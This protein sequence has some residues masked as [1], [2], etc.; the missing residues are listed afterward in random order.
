MEVLQASQWNQSLLRHHITSKSQ[1]AV[2]RRMSPISSPTPPSPPTEKLST[3]SRA[4]GLAMTTAELATQS[5]SAA[6]K[7]EESKAYY[8][9]PR[10]S[11]QRMGDS[12]AIDGSSMN[13]LFDLSARSHANLNSRSGPPN[14]AN[15]FGLMPEA[16]HA[17]ECISR[18]ASGADKWVAHPPFRFAVEFWDVA[19]LREK[20]RLHSHTIWYAGSLFNV[21]VQVVRKKGLQ[22]GVYLHRQS[23][24]DPTPS[25]STFAPTIRSSSSMQHV[26]GPSVPNTMSLPAPPP[27][28]S[29]SLRPT[30]SRVST[31]M[32]ISPA[33][34][35]V[36]ISSSPM[37]SNSAFYSSVTTTSSSLSSSSS[38]SSAMTIPA[39]TASPPP[40]QPYRDPRAAVTAYFSIACANATGSSLTRFTSAPDEFKVSQSWGWKSSSL[41]TEEYLDVGPDG[42]VLVVPRDAS[43]GRTKEISLRATVVIGVV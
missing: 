35:P 13:H 14:E 41:R 19:S 42:E 10:D 26:R 8:H 37:Q 3:E 6:H 33:T 11:S 9:V 39:A 22:L 16:Y 30:E 1:G 32:P 24:V 40:P 20:N 29:P 23:H 5:S 38:S 7:Q 43:A 31:P 28:Y 15:F 36:S 21:Y 12:A 4:L 25:M 18:D 17:S 2:S 34:I 27:H